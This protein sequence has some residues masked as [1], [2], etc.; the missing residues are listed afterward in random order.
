VSTG[1]SVIAGVVDTG[2]NFFYLA[3]VLV[4]V[5]TFSVCFQ[6]H[7]PRVKNKDAMEGGAARD[8][9]K[10]KGTKR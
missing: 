7:K 6:S 2:D 8:R 9:R 3:A 1:F 10:L 4:I 5:K